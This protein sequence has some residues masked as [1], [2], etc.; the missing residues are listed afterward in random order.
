MLTVEYLSLPTLYGKQVLSF[1]L[2]GH[3]NW[4]SKD[5]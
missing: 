2:M 4:S 1:V 3:P 5:I